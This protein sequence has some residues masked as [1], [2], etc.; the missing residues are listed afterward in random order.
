MAIVALMAV[1]IWRGDGVDIGSLSAVPWAATFQVVAAA[2]T[3]PA[4][5]KLQQLG[6]PV[7]L[8]QIGYVAAA[9]GL[10][11]GVLLLGERYGMLSWMGAAITAL[12]IA[13]TVLAQ[14]NRPLDVSLP[15]PLGR[16]TRARLGAC[17]APV[18]ETS[19][20]RIKVL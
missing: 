13:L 2:L 3:F 9:V 18:S 19:A 4:Y 7:L 1:M 14:R 6:G 5:F 16:R 10:V 8:S 11:I 12:G 17:A 15:M 20:P